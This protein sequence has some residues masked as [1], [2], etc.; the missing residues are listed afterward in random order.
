L[1]RTAPVLPLMPGVP[2]RRTHDYRRHGTTNLHA[3]LDVASGHVI[4]TMT[5][6]HRAAEFLAFLKL[7]DATVPADLAVHVVLDNVSTHKTPAVQRWLVRHPRFTL[8]FT[9][10]YSSWMNLVERWFAELTNKWLRGSTH[11]SVRGIV[12]SIRTWI[13]DWND[14]PRPFVWHKSADEVLDTLATYCQRISD[15]GH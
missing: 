10:T 14:N 13:T 4:H 11:R 8:H 12:A 6:R 2:E 7:I 1:D 5:A 3:A 9:P 15:S